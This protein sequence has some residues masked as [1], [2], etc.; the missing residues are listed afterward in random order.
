MF[1]PWGEDEGGIDMRR[2]R[3][4]MEADRS[5][6]SVKEKV[7]KKKTE[8]VRR[9]TSPDLRPQMRKEEEL[10]EERTGL[11]WKSIH[12]G[13]D[14]MSSDRVK[15]QK[16]D[17]EKISKALIVERGEP[18]SFSLMREEED[19]SG[20]F[21]SEEPYSL[22]NFTLNIRSHGQCFSDLLTSFFTSTYRCFLAMTRS[23]QHHHENIPIVQP[24]RRMGATGASGVLRRG[25]LKMPKC[26]L[27]IYKFAE[28]RQASATDWG[29]Q[30]YYGKEESRLCRFLHSDSQYLRTKEVVRE[31]QDGIVGEN[32]KS[33]KN[34]IAFKAREKEKT[35]PGSGL[36]IVAQKH[37]GKQEDRDGIESKWQGELICFAACFHRKKA[38]QRN[39]DVPLLTENEKEK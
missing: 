15:V 12:V 17:Q 31:F 21:R 38:D 39:K 6:R 14:G 10:L 36:A 8:M 7:K 20:R 25:N 28:Q 34:T 30:E 26:E 19:T 4:R 16:E 33:M 29:C 3:Q 18:D 2:I 23:P 9:S 1:S 24:W 32:F 11:S 27:E 22:K 35:P 37:V 13:A 5:T